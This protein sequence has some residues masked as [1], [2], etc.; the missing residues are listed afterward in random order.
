MMRFAAF[1]IQ[2]AEWRHGRSRDETKYRIV[3]ITVADI[4]I[5]NIATVIIK[6]TTP[7]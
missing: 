6:L 1:I 3:I 5:L 2:R 7:S 4:F